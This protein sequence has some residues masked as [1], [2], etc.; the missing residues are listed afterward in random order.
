MALF[1]LGLAG[2]STF[3]LVAALPQFDIASFDWLFFACLAG[4]LVGMCWL[5]LTFSRWESTLRKAPPGARAP[6]QFSIRAMF[7]WLLLAAIA[8]GT[9]ADFTS[10]IL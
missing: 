4:S 6:F 8:L 1:W 2:A 3:C 5:G 9:A 7:L 10:D